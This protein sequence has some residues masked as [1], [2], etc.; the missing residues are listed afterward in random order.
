[1]IQQETRLAVADNTGAKEVMCIKVL[2]GSRRR[3]AGLGDVI[4]CSVKSVVPGEIWQPNIPSELFRATVILCFTELEEA[5]QEEPLPV[6][7]TARDLPEFW[8]HFERGIA[9]RRGIPLVPVAVDLDVTRLPRSLLSRQAISV[10]SDN[11]ADFKELVELLERY[12]I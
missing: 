8:I 3:F 5:P 10:R 12:R 11:E 2:G 1:M 4:V 6:G 7:V 9:R